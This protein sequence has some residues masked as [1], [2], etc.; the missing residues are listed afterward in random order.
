MILDYLG[1][2]NKKE[3]INYYNCNYKGL[4]DGLCVY[5]ISKSVKYSKEDLFKMEDITSALL[6]NEPIIGEAFNSSEFGIL[7][8]PYLIPTNNLGFNRDLLQVETDLVIKEF[9]LNSNFSYIKD[10]IEIL[11]KNNIK[12]YKY[13]LGYQSDIELLQ[14][15]VLEK[16]SRR[17]TQET[18]DKVWRRDEGKCVE[19]CSNENLEFDHIIPHSK[20]GANTYRNIQLLCESC[21]RSKSDKIG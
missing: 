13:F 20:G 21:N 11:E 6:E 7:I 2:L 12:Y 14:N 18:K 16:K 4:I 5:N 9:C 10:K 15:G 1:V 3:R 17:I 8:S 19:C